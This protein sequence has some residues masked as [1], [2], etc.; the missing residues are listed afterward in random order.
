MAYT[1]DQTGHGFGIGRLTTVTDAAGRLSRFYDER[2]N[3]LTESRVDGAVTLLTTTTYDAASRI[4]SITYPSG[5]KV[6][7]TRDV[8]GRITAMA[9]QLP[10]ES[11]PQAVVSG[12]A[13]E[14]FGPVSALTYSNGVAD[15]RLFD[16]DYRLTNLV[17]TG[18]A[19]LQNLTYGY[20]AG[21]NVLSVGDAVTPGNSQDLGYDALNRLDTATGSY[22]SLAYTYD[23]VGNRLTQASGPTTSTYNY[24]PHSNQ[25]TTIKSGAVTQ[26]IAYIGAGNI[27]SIVP[28][29]GTATTLT[30]NQAN[31]L[32]SVTGIPL[33]ISSMVYDAFGKRVSK[34]SGGTTNYFTYGQ[35]GSLLEEDDAGFQ[36]DYLYLNGSLAAEITGGKLYY[37]LYDR[38]G[39][40]Q[41][42]TGSN[43][44]V[45]WSATY[46]PFGN[47][48]PTGTITQNLRLPG[49]YFDAESG[50]NHNGFRDYG[51]SLGRY[52]ESDPI[53]LAGGTNSYAYSQDNPLVWFD[54]SGLYPVLEVTLPNGTQYEP[55]TTIKNSVQAADLGLPTGT[56]VP[57]AVPPGVDPQALVNSW[58]SGSLFNGLGEFAWTCAPADL[59]T[60]NS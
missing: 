48:S 57:I 26:A 55:S 37:V 17:D 2:G 60:T 41:V 10:G 34:S 16:L 40:P 7:Y 19:S 12:V 13:Y 11:Q 47:A 15:N 29:N 39:T 36:T 25:L 23:A 30:Y 51:P 24:A 45:A 18:T 4:S 3:I 14:P 46:Q 38:L 6:S 43:Q 27:S 44:K 58:G 31:R 59:M 20:D 33:A 56:I 5:S 1:Y 8:M 28:S 50:W 32:A 54:S 52:L 35:D 21:N 49:Q 42:V 9:A 53:G 22:G